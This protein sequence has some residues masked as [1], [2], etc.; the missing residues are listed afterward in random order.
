MMANDEMKFFRYNTDANHFAGIGFSMEDDERITNVHF[1][2]APLAVG[3]KTPGAHGFDEDPEEEGDF[4]TLY[5]FGEIPVMSQRAWDAL[6]TVI[7]Y[8]SEPL[9]INHPSGKPY[10]IAHV[11]QTIPCLDE[12]R[13]VVR[14]SSIDGRISRVHRY[15]LKTD[16]LEGKHIFKLPL[17]CGGELLVDDDFRRLV[18]TNSLV[19]LRFDELPMV[20]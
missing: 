1:T 19:G 7:G 12:E 16:M 6:G 17:E 9:P 11:M 5:N 15:A 13:S 14:R 20:E 10:V 3:W 18:E 2:D 8:C 4:P